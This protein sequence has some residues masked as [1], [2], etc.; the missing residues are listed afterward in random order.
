VWNVAHRGA[1]AEAPENTLR[2]FELAIKQG[3][4]VV[5][6]DIRAS[7]DD[8]MLVL[9]D[10]TLD[11]T[12]SGRGPLAAITAAEARGLDA[13][14]GQRIPRLEEVLEIA[15]G[16]V[17]VNL[18]LKELAVVGPAVDAVREA[19]MLDQV[20]F[21][22]F[23][24]EAWDRLGELSPQSPVVHLLHSAAGLAGLAMGEVGT[25]SV[26]AG[27]GIPAELVGPELVERMHRHGFG[28]FA[29]TID[30]EDLM[31]RLVEAGVNG[32]VTNRPGALAEVLRQMRGA[33]SGAGGAQPGATAGP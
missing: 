32:V 27:V 22:S 14:E 21:I 3:A 26:G 13:G 4:D 5:E 7:S 29:W 10:A 28:V 9:H 25:Q 6:A 20:T 24:P 16:R 11:R 17:R 30:D 12:T 23:L 1:S 15:R 2:A 33:A 19:G 8:A 31:R 18:D